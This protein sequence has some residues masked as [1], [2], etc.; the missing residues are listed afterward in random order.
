MS[1]RIGRRYF[2]KQSYDAIIIGG[3][4][5]GLTAAAYLAKAGKKVCVLER[6]HVLGGAAVTEEIVPGFRFSRASYLLSLLRPVVMQEL[7]LKKFGLRYHIRNPNSFTPIRNT[8]ESL[9]LGMN[10]EENQKEI[11]KFSKADAEN[12]PKYEHFIS[13]ITHSFE[14]LMDYEPLDLQKPIH[15]LFPHL[16]LLFKT[17][18]PLGLR[19]AVDF[20]ELMTAPIS[21]IM[22]KW[23]ESDVLKATLGT[24]GVIGLAASPMDPGTGYVLLHHVIGGLDEHKGAWGYVYGGM[25]AVSN[26]IA[27]CAKAHGAEIYTEQEVDEV[28]LDGNIAKGVRLSNGKEIHSKIVMSN[29][30]PHVTFNQLVKK[31]SLPTD[32]YR[33][34]SQIDYT[35]P[36]TK[37][38]VAVKELPNFLAKPNQGSEPMPHHQ[39]TIHMNCENMQV[40]HDAV[41]DYKN[42]R[43]SRRPV[44]EMT[45]PS[46]VDRTIVD[47]KDGHVV[48]LFTQYTPFSPKDHEWTEEKKTEYAK[49][50]FSEID[51]YAPNFSSSVI[52][53][54][55]LTPPDIQNTFGITGGNIF[56]GSMS[57]DQLYLSRPVSKWANYSTPIQ[58]LYLCGSGAHPGGGV[59]GAPGRLSAL[60]ALKHI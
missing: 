10:M 1:F 57:L 9:L 49:H 8:H 6:R 54:D 13:E 24:D 38:N 17:L 12:Y 22:N 47:S 56:H 53:Y 36:V 41:L 59:T 23:F 44:I 28:I 34:I 30:T 37:I 11:A 18:Q 26:A 7:N 29:A 42:G 45:I 58:S 3:G 27:E 60:H 48:L 51:A 52:G 15:K 35:S 46:S 43:Y 40:V 50:V 2:S 25:G 33:S 31:E 20:Y 39:T 16:Y 21:K 32:F 4:H 14:Q 5:N 19:N 55:I